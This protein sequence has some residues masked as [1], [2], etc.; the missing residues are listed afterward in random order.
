MYFWKSNL[1]P[2][3]LREHIEKTL[4]RTL[5]DRLPTGAGYRV[6]EFLEECQTI[7]SGSKSDK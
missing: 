6:H 5:K 3:E 4:R 1:I 7:M 2:I